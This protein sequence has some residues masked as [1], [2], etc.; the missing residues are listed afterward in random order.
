[1]INAGTQGRSQEVGSMGKKIC[2]LTLLIYAQLLFYIAQAP[3]PK[4]G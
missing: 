1:M 4:Y 2:L 3:L